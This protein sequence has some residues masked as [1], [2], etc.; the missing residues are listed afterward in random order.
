MDI[1][2]ADKHKWKLV[3]GGSRIRLDE[4]SGEGQAPYKRWLLKC[5]CHTKCLRKRS[6]T[7]CKAHGRIEPLAYLMV[8]HEL[9]RDVTLVTDKKAHFQKRPSAAQVAE[10]VNAHGETFAA[11]FFD[12]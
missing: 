3:D 1:A 2:G 6:L 10:W 4:W 12:D 9:G 5:G 7:Q 8:W 11:S